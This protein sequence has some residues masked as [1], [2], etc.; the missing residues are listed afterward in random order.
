M[1]TKQ[2]GEKY[3]SKID[4]IV[5]QIVRDGLIESNNKKDLINLKKVV[6]QFASDIKKYPT[7]IGDSKVEYE[8]DQKV[9][10]I[11]KDLSILKDL[12]E[13]SIKEISMLKK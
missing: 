3:M 4:E 9:S 10:R 1:K 13:R 2:N 5:D 6:M 8:M 12:I 11:S 7:S